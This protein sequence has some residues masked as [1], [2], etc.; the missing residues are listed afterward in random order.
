MG[1]WVFL[2]LLVVSFVAV[3]VL[4]RAAQPPAGPLPGATA[5]PQ[6]IA[7]LTALPQAT[8]LSGEAVARLD[9]L[10]AA[11]D[12]CADYSE[13]RR[14][15]MHQHIDWLIN[16]SMILPDIIPALGA[17]P[18]GKLVFGMVTYTLGE[19][20]RAGRSP[21]SCLVSIGHTLNAMLVEAGEEPFAAFDEVDNP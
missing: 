17:N 10:R 21:D 6:I 4:A 20:G 7:N 15:Q 18:T 2:A 3:I 9:D 14:Q 16:P 13:A 11:V 5:D 12:A 1:L 19:W 8:A